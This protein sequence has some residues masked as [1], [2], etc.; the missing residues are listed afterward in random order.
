MREPTVHLSRD[1]QPSS[2]GGRGFQQCKLFHPVP[3]NGESLLTPQ[4]QKREQGVWSKLQRGRRFCC[5]FS[6]ATRLPHPGETFDEVKPIRSLS[7][8]ALKVL[9]AVKVYAEILG[10]FSL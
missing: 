4:L 1:G 5:F 9:K 6:G 10:K 7:E 8:N 3:L 2:A